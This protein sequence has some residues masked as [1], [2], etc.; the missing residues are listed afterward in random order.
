MLGTHM[1]ITLMYVNTL[2]VLELEV[3]FFKGGCLVEGFFSGAA[4]VP[5]LLLMYCFRSYLPRMNC[6]TALE[7]MDGSHDQCT[8][9]T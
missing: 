7:G 3:S 2:F 8:V 1:S 4:W 5:P 6:S 9:H